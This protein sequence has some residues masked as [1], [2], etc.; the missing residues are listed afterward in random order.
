VDLSVFYQR[1]PN[2]VDQ[3]IGFGTAFEWDIDLLSGYAYEVVEGESDPR[4]VAPSAHAKP[5]NLL[6]RL[7]EKK[8][9]LALSIGWY[10]PYLRRAIFC[11]HRLGVPVMV[12]G[13][14]QVDPDQHFAKRFIKQ[15]SY[16]LLLR[17]FSAGLYVG[18]RSREYFESFGYPENRLF[19]SPHAIETNRFHDTA[20]RVNKTESRKDLG[21]GTDEK[22]LLF[23]GKLVDFKRPFVAIETVAAL[24]ELG[25]NAKLVVAGTGPLEA[26]MIEHAKKLKVSVNLLGFVNQTEMPETYAVADAL[27]LPSTRRETWGLV[28]NEALACGTPIVVSNEAGCAADLCDGLAGIAGEGNDAASYARGL[29]QIWS[30]DTIEKDVRAMSDRHSIS[31]AANGILEAA[32]FI[33]GD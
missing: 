1:I 28:A 27:I 9:D 3:G 10:S 2:S 15:L 22:L 12:R 30:R 13:D 18:T 8:F 4:S 17:L 23:A 16:P 25:T 14:S 32:S 26:A 24:R 29:Q 21:V 6:V 11:A 31:A 19:Y 20:F 5:T 33:L 7:R